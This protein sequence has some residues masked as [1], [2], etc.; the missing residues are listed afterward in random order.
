MDLSLE[1]LD[2][3]YDFIVTS[4]HSVAK[5]SANANSAFF[6]IDSVRALEGGDKLRETDCHFC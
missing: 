2:R 5:V 4:F 3:K 1:L 6:A